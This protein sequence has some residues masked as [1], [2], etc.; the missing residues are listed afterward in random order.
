[1]RRCQQKQIYIEG[2][3]RIKKNTGQFSSQDVEKMSNFENHE[4]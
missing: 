1:M 3:H 2:N 4:N